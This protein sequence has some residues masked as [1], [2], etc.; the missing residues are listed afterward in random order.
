MRFVALTVALIAYAT[1]VQA[2]QVGRYQIVAVPRSQGQVSNF[3]VLDTATGQTWIRRN[4]AEKHPIG[5]RQRVVII[6]P[7]NRRDPIPGQLMIATA[8]KCLTLAP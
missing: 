8:A 4:A 1:Q 2:Q 3:I 7:D 6:L 5:A